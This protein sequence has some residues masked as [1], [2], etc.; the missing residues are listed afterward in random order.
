MKAH[1]KY[2][3]FV[4]Q[5]LRE[6]YCVDAA[7]GRTFVGKSTGRKITVD[8]SFETTTIGGAKV[9][10]VLECKHYRRRVS[11][12]HVESFKTRIEDIAAHKGIMVTTVGYQSGTEKVAVAHGIGLALLTR[13]P[14]PGE[15][16]LRYIVAS[17]SPHFDHEPEPTNDLLQGNIVG[18]VSKSE[19][20]FRFDRF[21]QLLGLLI[22]D[23]S[24]RATK[25]SGN[26]T[27]S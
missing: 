1:D 27:E 2:E 4:T 7:R 10:V 11:V 13:D 14:R 16:P 8:V 23:L 18:L 5:L 25:E 19:A 21:S 12:G 24:A 26:T 9:L 22:V 15:L 6:V 3:E 20:G 17:S